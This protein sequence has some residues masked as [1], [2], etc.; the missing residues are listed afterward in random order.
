M[1]TKPPSNGT[2]TSDAAAV[3]IAPI[4]GR[5]AREVL[6]CLVSR[7]EHG[8]TSDEVEAETGHPGNTVRTR[9]VA[10][11]RAGLVLATDRVR[12]TRAGRRAVVYQAIVGAGS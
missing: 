8:G 1:N 7:G 11:R 6:A 9:I 12:P 5:I 4:A 3:A 10:L 2:R